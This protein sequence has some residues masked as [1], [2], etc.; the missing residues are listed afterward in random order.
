M[1]TGRPGTTGW[2]GV[3]DRVRRSRLPAGWRDGVP[4]LLLSDVLVQQGRQL[5][6]LVLKQEV[7]LGHVEGESSYQ[8][9]VHHGQA[10]KLGVADEALPAEDGAV[11][12]A[13]WRNTGSAGPPQMPLSTETN[14]PTQGSNA[15][16]ATL[17][18]LPAFPR[19]WLPHLSH[20][21]PPQFGTDPLPSFLTL[22]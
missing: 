12:A 22:P 19:I 3:R 6:G 16:S 11:D 1:F 9:P 8:L 21:A 17:L 2:L 10:G 14:G 18:H 13:T 4:L 20:P 15:R 5:E 7:G